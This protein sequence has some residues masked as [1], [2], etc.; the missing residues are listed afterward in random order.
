MRLRKLKPGGTF[1]FANFSPEMIDDGFMETVMNWALLQRSENDIWNI[2]NASV[3]R[4]TVEARVFFGE[5]RNVLYGVI[6]KHG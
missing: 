1:L 4:N 2:I 3:D 6:E 5:N